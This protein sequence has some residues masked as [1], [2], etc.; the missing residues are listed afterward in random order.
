M[1][2]A[3]ISNCGKVGKTTLVANWLAPRIPDSVIIAV[4]SINETAESMGIESVEKLKGA[5]FRQLFKRLTIEDSA[6][7]DIGASNIE[8]FMDQIVK[9]ED[10]HELIDYYVIPVVPGMIEQRESVQTIMGLLNIGIPKEKIKIVFN[11]VENDVQDDFAWF[12]L[13]AHKLV[14]FSSKAFIPNSELFGLMTQAQTTVSTLLN[15]DTDYKS[16]LKSTPKDDI[17]EIERITNL[18]AMKA[19]AKPLSRRFDALFAEVFNDR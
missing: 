9:F 11:R 2:V 3:T 10:A 19:M 18:L 15:D 6:I 17:D 5:N 1:K 8:D 4:E 7:V 13:N 16:I 12:A 14:K